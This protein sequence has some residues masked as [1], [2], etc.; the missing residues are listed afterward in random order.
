[1][2]GLPSRK[3]A[4]IGLFRPF[5]E[6]LNST[7]KIQKKQQKG[8]FL[9]YPRI[10]SKPHLLN[11]HSGNGKSARSFSDRSFF[12][13]VRAGWPFR[14]AC[15]SRIVRRISGQKLPLWAEFSFLTWHLRYYQNSC[16]SHFSGVHLFFEVFQDFWHSNKEHQSV[17]WNAALSCPSMVSNYG[18][19]EGSRTS[20]DAIILVFWGSQCP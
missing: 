2:S 9:G 6:G 16:Q 4:E 14:N 13:D 7:G 10:C 19:L 11:P 17:S 3:S 5:P 8:L 12:M 1:M 18:K 20:C 15:F